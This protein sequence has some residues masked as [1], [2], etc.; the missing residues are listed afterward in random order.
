MRKSTAAL[1]HCITAFCPPSVGSTV[2]G[3]PS[4]RY[5]KSIRVA[6]SIASSRTHSTCEI[7]DSSNNCFPNSVL[8]TLV[9]LSMMLLHTTY[10]ASI[11]LSSAHATTHLLTISGCPESVLPR[12][13][14][15]PRM[16]HLF[17][18]GSHLT[19]IRNSFQTPSG[20][21]NLE[22]PTEIILKVRPVWLSKL[23]VECSGA[24]GT[25][26]RPPSIYLET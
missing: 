19:I 21:Q 25:N 8:E 2:H 11:S 15:A 26:Q 5:S 24:T 16:L 3:A 4:A 9:Q 13:G 12:Y 7:T 6:Q 17:R 10:H 22:A 1:N 14:C 23:I 20:A 18:N